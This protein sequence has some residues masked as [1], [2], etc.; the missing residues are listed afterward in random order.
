MW[1]KIEPRLAAVT[2][3]KPA[4]PAAVKLVELSAMPGG[5][6]LCGG[7]AARSMRCL[8][9]LTVWET[10]DK[11]DWHVCNCDWFNQDMFH[12][13][14]FDRGRKMYGSAREAAHAVTYRGWVKYLN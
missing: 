13:H 11:W 10:G 12:L 9:A 8:M 1:A 4:P 14:Y 7:H 5:A 3:K 6:E 2:T